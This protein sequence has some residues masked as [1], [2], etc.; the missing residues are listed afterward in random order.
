MEQEQVSSESVALDTNG[1]TEQPEQSIY[2]L[3]SAEKFKWQGREWTTKELQNN[4][5]MHSDYTRK[6]QAIAE[7][8]K[9]Y[10]NLN[11]DLEAVSRNPN[12]IAE[13]K[14]I[15]PEK[16]H[17]FL[18]YTS[19]KSTQPVQQQQSQS[20]IDPAFM[21]RFEKLEKTMN[22]REV[23]AV[24][25]ELESKFKQLSSKYPMADEEAVI[26]RA[27]TLLNR[28]ENVSDQVWDNLWKNVHEKNQK[29]ADAYYQNKI[30]EQKTASAKGKDVPSGGGTL[31]QAPKQ[32]RTIREAS[33][34]LMAEQE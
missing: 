14:K 11:S 3:D 33:A 7:E 22:E 25:A 26:A 1:T 27:Q 2:D 15:Y 6:T 30:K 21:N 17:S 4:Y 5:L 16:F 8:R 24:E 28:N 34:M 32:A 13:F 29:L 18:N 12:L 19:P 20:G 9:Y 23:A 10:D 31:G